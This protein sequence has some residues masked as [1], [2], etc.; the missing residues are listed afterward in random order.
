MM[1]MM[2]V[3]VGFATLAP[4]TWSVPP[5]A[6]FIITSTVFILQF[7][8]ASSSRCSSLKTPAILNWRVLIHVISPH[9]PRVR[10]WHSLRTCS[11][12]TRSTHTT[13][14][15]TDPRKHPTKFTL[16]SRFVS[17]STKLT[18]RSLNCLGKWRYTALSVDLLDAQETSLLLHLLGFFD[19]SPCRRLLR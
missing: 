17:W 2:M 6:A 10:K 14:P 4:S 11:H 19:C 8:S 18:L 13:N 5:R 9:L 12:W 15:T 16:D 7:P 1:V 3:V